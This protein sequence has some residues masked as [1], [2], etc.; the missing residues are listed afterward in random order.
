M[1]HALRAAEMP[2]GNREKNLSGSICVNFR[3]YMHVK[4]SITHIDLFFIS[5]FIHTSRMS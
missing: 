5:C 1:F 4:N 3:L 2:L